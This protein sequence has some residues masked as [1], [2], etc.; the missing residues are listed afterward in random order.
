MEPCLP[1]DAKVGV[2]VVVVGFNCKLREVGE[3]TVFD[4]VGG[5]SGNVVGSALPL[6]GLSAALSSMAVV[7]VFLLWLRNFGVYNFGWISYN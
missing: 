3:D 4:R 1:T 2:V 7:V 6:L 5:D